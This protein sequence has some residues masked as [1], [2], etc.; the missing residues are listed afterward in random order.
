M[1][2][3]NDFD[4]NSSSGLVSVKDRQDCPWVELMRQDLPNFLTSCR[5]LPHDL[6]SCSDWF[7]IPVSMVC[8]VS[9]LTYG[10]HGLQTDF[11]FGSSTPRSVCSSQVK[12]VPFRGCTN[13]HL[14]NNP[15]CFLSSDKILVI[16]PVL[17]Y[18]D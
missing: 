8:M 12:W 11:K 18:I 1:A 7:D 4:A 5:E 13:C 2:G 14:L 9:Y 16:T 6:V 10:L 3:H 15:I 17:I